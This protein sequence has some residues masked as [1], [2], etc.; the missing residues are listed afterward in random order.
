PDF[1][2]TRHLVISPFCTPG[3]LNRCAPSGALSVVSRQEALDRL[4]E[5]SLA[6]SE[7]FVVSALAGL[8]A[9]EA[10]PGQEALHGLHAKVY[11]V[12][13]GHQAR[14]LL[15]SANATDAAFSGNVELL[16]ELG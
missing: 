16:V 7:A 5:G 11:V 4:P 9:E 10:P 13:K 12:E 2:G 14:V 3:G 6:G 8:P 15:G 1:A